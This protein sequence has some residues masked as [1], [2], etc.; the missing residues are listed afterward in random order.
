[1]KRIGRTA[2]VLLG[3]ALTVVTV[4]EGRSLLERK[5]YYS[6]GGKAGECKFW[7]VYLGSHECTLRRKFPG[8]DTTAVDANMNFS[9]LSSGYI[10][11]NGFGD[12][13]KIDC[14]A[15]FAIRTGET[16]RRLPIDSIA[17]I[18]GGGTR[19]KTV[20]GERGDFVIDVEG[21]LLVPTTFRLRNYKLTDYYGEEILKDTQ[22]IP[23]DA[24][25][26]RKE[27]LRAAMAEDK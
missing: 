14:L 26:F 21:Q 23:L 17:Y 12:R 13:G 15:E 22:E 25:A 20:H 16:S 8:E 9:I 18:Y 7:A 24:V 4:I 1:M 2:V 10:E 11:G 27:G 6:S 19:I 3:L 5:M